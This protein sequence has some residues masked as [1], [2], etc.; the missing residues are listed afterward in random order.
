MRI[1]SEAIG[2]LESKDETV[3]PS[4]DASVTVVVICYNSTP[5][6]ERCLGSIVTAIPPGT[7]IL[8]I[9]NASA[10][11]SAEL[12]LRIAPNCRLIALPQN[13]GHSAACNLALQLAETT[14][15][16]LLDHDTFVSPDWF[17]PLLAAAAQTWPATAMVSSRVIFE[18]GTRLH[19]DGGYV[20]FVGHMTLNHGFSS[21]DAYPVRPGE[22]WEV[23]ALAATSLLIHRERALE[24]GG[25]DARYFIYLNDWELA[26]RMRLRG[27]RCYVAPNSI[28]YH[29][30][31]NKETSWRG[32]GA[33]P[34]R[35]AFLIYRNRWMTLIKLYRART[36]LLCAPAVLLYDLLLLVAAIRNGWFSAYIAALRDVFRHR[37]SLWLQ[38]RR[39][40]ATRVIGDSAL[41]DARHLSFVPGLVRGPERVVQ[42][43]LEYLFY[44]YWQLVKPFLD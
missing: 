35:R 18:D 44:V 5:Y 27:W 34:L 16:L 33:Y 36:L 42:F 2:L 22:I 3:S 4:F 6:L 39:I 32:Q 9:D 14:W 12:A 38:R 31:G 30:S 19:H 17:A 8:V 28:V 24:V 15:I 37:R 13:I 10:D 43:V 20:H 1:E 29:R 23:G 26:L 25:F 41:L 40:Q 21:P 7:P 11:G